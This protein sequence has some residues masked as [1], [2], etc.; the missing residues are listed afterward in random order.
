MIMIRYLYANAGRFDDG[1]KFTSTERERTLTIDLLRSESRG[2]VHKQCLSDQG[3][4]LS[5]CK[6]NKVRFEVG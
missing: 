2:T 4:V 6:R 3:G 5:V 1:G